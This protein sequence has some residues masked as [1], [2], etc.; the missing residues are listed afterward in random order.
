MKNECYKE[1]VNHDISVVTIAYMY[2]LAMEPY[3][4]IVIA[5]LKV[6]STFFQYCLK[7]HYFCLVL[8]LL[9]SSRR[10]NLDYQD[11]DG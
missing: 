1:G 7:Y 11:S 9:G 4:D 2:Y 6:H 5:S 3:I 10:L 8:E